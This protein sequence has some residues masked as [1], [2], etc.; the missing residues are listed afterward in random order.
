MTGLARRLSY[1]GS[2]PGRL[3]GR[4]VR[5]VEWS[6]LS[7]PRL[8]WRL[9]PLAQGPLPEG[10]RLCH[11]VLDALGIEVIAEGLHH[12]PPTGPVIVLANHPTGILDGAALLSALFTVRRDARILARALAADLPQIAPL[13]LPVPY[14]HAADRRTVLRQLRQSARAHLQAGGVV[15]LFPAGRI[16]EGEEPEW[17]GFALRL[18]KDTGATVLP[19]A[20]LDH[21]SRLYRTAARLHPVLRQGVL[22]QEV[23]RRT[24]RPFRVRIGKPIYPTGQ[25]IGQIRDTVCALRDA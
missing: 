17:S 22:L 20:I 11:R 10:M 4:A 24:D 5:L 6:S 21:S 25:T 12:V 18:A 23:L 3:S 1:A 7:T 2:L 14:A 15:A 13:I 16:A 19:V 9:A 8:L